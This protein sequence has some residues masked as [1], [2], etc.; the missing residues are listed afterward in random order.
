MT[1]KLWVHSIKN[2]FIKKMTEKLYFQF[3]HKFIFF[4]IEK[5]S[6]KI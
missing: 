3:Y 5:Y 4:K 1:L 2:K 6:K